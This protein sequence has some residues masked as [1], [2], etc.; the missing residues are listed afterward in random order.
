MGGNGLY[1][2]ICGVVPCSIEGQNEIDRVCTLS[3]MYV[4]CQ[5]H[6]I[7]LHTS[8]SIKQ[9]TQREE[10]AE[11]RFIL[12]GGG[13]CTQARKSSLNRAIE[14]VPVFLSRTASTV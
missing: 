4:S 10:S 1:F 7:I 2:Y 8:Q 5:S 12:R 6:R 9:W 13:G 3:T 14:N 11:K